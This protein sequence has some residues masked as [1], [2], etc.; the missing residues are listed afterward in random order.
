MAFLTD[1]IKNRWP[2]NHGN[3]V[4]N[5]NAWGP[6]ILLQVHQ[7]SLSSLDSKLQDSTFV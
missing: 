5:L 4:E 3:Q 7:L 2:K 6:L 1:W